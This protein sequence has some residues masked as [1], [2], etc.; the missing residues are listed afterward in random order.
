M[1]FMRFGH[2]CD[3]GLTDMPIPTVKLRV[4]ANE[5]SFTELTGGTHFPESDPHSRAHLAA[6]E[7]MAAIDDACRV[8]QWIGSNEERRQNQAAY[9]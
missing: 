7:I 5:H 8:E 9:R 2:E 4:G 3:W 6:V 1:D